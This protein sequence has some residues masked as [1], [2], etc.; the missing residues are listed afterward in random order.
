MSTG[1]LIIGI[2]C[3]VVGIILEISGWDGCDATAIIGD[4][5]TILLG[6]VIII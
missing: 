1:F 3:I 2:I 4:I 6:I 5:V